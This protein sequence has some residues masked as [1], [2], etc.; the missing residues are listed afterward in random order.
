MGL[1]MKG[2]LNKKD[3]THEK[4]FNVYEYGAATIPPVDES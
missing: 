2:T 1:R 4:S 3:E